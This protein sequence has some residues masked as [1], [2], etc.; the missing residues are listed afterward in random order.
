MADKTCWSIAWAER[1]P[2]EAR[3]FNPAFCGELIGRTVCEYQRMRLSALNMAIAFLVLPLTLHRP[4]CDS[5]PGRA[6]TAFATWVVEH[7]ALLVELPSS[8]KRLRPVTREALLF[9]IRYQL[10]AIDGG[11]LVPG[12]KPVRLNAKPVITTED[13]SAARSAAGLLGRWFAGQGTQASIL[14]GMGVAP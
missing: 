2:E 14:Q 8:V 5:L 1:P 3:I 7:G 11:G 4:M 12:A 10:L 6:N 13:V 9:A